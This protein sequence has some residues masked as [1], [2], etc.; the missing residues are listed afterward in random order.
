MRIRTLT[1]RPAS[2]LPFHT[3]L[4]RMRGWIHLLPGLF[5][6]FL[7]PTLLL[8]GCEPTEGELL[9][10]VAEDEGI[11]PDE[12]ETATFAI[13]GPGMPTGCHGNEFFVDMGTPD[14]HQ[15]LWN[16]WHGIPISPHFMVYYDTPLSI[17]P[18]DLCWVSFHGTMNTN[19]YGGGS[20]NWD[21]VYQN[22]RIEILI[23]MSLRVRY[24]ISNSAFRN[25]FYLWSYWEQ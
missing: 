7:V 15:V 6:V 1:S 25:R 10:Q 20:D 17:G 19:S 4:L 5:A 9:M 3:I 13:T 8:T 22:G 21:A 24:S 14:G 2:R 12:L 11:D 16:R 23:P 18:A